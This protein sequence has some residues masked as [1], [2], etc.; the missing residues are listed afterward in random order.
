MSARFLLAGVLFA[1][2][3]G[4]SVSEPGGAAGAQS[5]PPLPAGVELRAVWGS[6]PS[7]VWAVGASGTIVHFDGSAWAS[8][9]SG[10]TENLTSV[11]GTGPDD[12]W[13][14]G[15]GGSL[16]HWDGTSWSTSQDN[17]S[18]GLLG[19][20]AVA[21][22]EVWAVGI[23]WTGGSTGNGSGFVLHGEGGA[24]QTSDVGA[25]SSLW[26]VWASGPEDVWFGGDGASGGGV[27][28]RGAGTPRSPFDLT[29]Y[30]GPEVRGIWGDA[31]NDVWVTPHEAAV[32]H[33]DGAAW[34]SAASM[35]ASADVFGATGTSSD[36]VWAVGAGGTAY[37]YDG[38]A[39][40]A[41]TT[42]TSALLA[43]AWSDSSGHV[44]A[45]GAEVAL[46]WDGH[47]W[48]L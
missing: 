34:S 1:L 3:C 18:T 27:V 37:H 21:P 42:G 43:G 28:V 36:D 7:D 45:V 10:V 6:G 13:T 25:A 47:S 48:Q 29:T 40:S 12:A 2:G 15:D 24:W 8:V 22:G 38:R 20:W 9:T 31:T 23:D 4:G 32:V 33:W 41:S 14:T 30:A 17:E 11:S 44:W 19:V 46:R 16:L 35:P 39:W 5:L 26:T